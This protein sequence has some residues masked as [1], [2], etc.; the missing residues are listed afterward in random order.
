M[1]TAQ[2]SLGSAMQ[3]T[4][5]VG[6]VG[7]LFM[8]SL[9]MRLK[10]WD[11]PPLPRNG[12]AIPDKTFAY[13]G[14]FMSRWESLEFELS[15]LHSHFLGALDETEAM[16]AYGSG[17]IFPDRI[18]ILKRAA[19]AHFRTSPNQKREGQFDGL[20]TEARGYAD[21]RNEIAH[22]IVFRISEITFFRE[23]LKPQLLHR[24]HWALIPPLYASKAHRHSGIPGYGYAA[25][26]MDR[27]AQRVMNLQSRI[28][29]LHSG[30]NS[31][32]I[33]PSPSR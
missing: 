28:R 4:R 17:R 32:A 5:G 33:S 3:A 7:T 27:L 24:E 26:A 16:R 29:S 2:L 31:L 18:A 11:V 8:Y 12:D 25:T 9:P 6:P 15:R 10:P 13:V 23:R 19:D 14:F 21:R 20:L 1:P 30:P 22:G